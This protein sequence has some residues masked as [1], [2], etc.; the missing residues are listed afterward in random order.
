MVGEKLVLQIYLNVGFVGGRT[1][2][3]SDNLVPIDVVIGAGVAFDPALYRREAMVLEGTKYALRLEVRHRYRDTG[4]H[5]EF[6]IF[7]LFVTTNY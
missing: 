5:K 6:C 3:I 7:Y 2:F 1:T 4:S